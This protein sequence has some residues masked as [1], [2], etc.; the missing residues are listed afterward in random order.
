MATHD[1]LYLGMLC[2]NANQLLLTAKYF[3]VHVTDARSE[4]GMVHEDDSWRTRSLGKHFF[5]PGDACGAEAATVLAGRN[6]IQ[7]DKT[8]RETFYGVADVTLA[9]FF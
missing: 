9:I 1:S 6:R 4:R 5:E 7:A 2:D 3:F 8:Y